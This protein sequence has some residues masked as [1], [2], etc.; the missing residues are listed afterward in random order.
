MTLL[1]IREFEQSVASN[2]FWFDLHYWN[3][4]WPKFGFIA[5]CRETKKFFITGNR[6]ARF[7]FKLGPYDDLET[8]RVAFMT[9]VNLNAVPKELV[10]TP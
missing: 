4:D 8:A 10:N 2:H 1:S 5:R 6:N 3:G 7:T 9:M